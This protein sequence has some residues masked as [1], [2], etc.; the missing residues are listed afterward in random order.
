MANNFL[1]GS[2]RDGLKQRNRG[3]AAAAAAAVSC[4]VF[5]SLRG[6][7]LLALVWGSSWIS[8]QFLLFVADQKRVVEKRWREFFLDPSQWWDH[9]SEKVK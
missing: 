6:L 9:R 4:L 3:K 8:H 1:L 2:Q 7:P 5:V